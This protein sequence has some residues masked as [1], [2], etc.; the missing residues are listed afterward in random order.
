MCRFFFFSV[1]TP[2][3]EWQEVLVDGLRRELAANIEVML[4]KQS[5]DHLE[6]LRL[7]NVILCVSCPAQP[8][9]KAD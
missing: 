5:F 1:P 2:L 3:C 9:R 8:E 7:N 4:A 6:V